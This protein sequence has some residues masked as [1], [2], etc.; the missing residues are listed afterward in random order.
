MASQTPQS[1]GFWYK[2]VHL[3]PALVRG[4]VMAVFAFLAS[5]GILVS[6]AV[7]DNLVGVVLALFAIIQALWTRQVVVPEERVVVWKDDNQ[8]LRAG[9]AVPT[10]AGGETHNDTLVQL[11]QAA[12]SKGKVF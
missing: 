1:Q 10:L 7:P 8:N 3:E 9:E 6:D 5:V 11:E 12:Y 4:L 2:L